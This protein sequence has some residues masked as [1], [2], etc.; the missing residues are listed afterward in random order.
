ME[1]LLIIRESAVLV[2]KE[3]N[4]FGTETWKWNLVAMEMGLGTMIQFSC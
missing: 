4:R 1:Y 2:A 3:M